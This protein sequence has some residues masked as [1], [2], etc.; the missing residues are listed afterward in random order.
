MDR[1]LHGL[2]LQKS[3]MILFSY[4]KIHLL[5]A[6]YLL[7][8]FQNIQLLCIGFKNGIT[9]IKND[10]HYTKMVNTYT[11]NYDD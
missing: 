11:E 10:Q 7:D 3:F 1:I 5:F 8:T 9:K 6:F 2:K 4:N